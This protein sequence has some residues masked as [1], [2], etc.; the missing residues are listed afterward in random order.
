M[1]Q[2]KLAF[3]NNE[4]KNAVLALLDSGKAAD[5]RGAFAIVMRERGIRYDK[6]SQKETYSVHFRIT[7]PLVTRTIKAR[8]LP[9][10][11]AKCQQ[12]ISAPASEDWHRHEFA[13]RFREG[14]L[15]G[16]TLD[17]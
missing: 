7:E 6:P 16:F 14:Q 4:L 10:P 13:I 1:A 3:G 5:F 8:K 11:K 15:S 12:K 9:K 17:P 2:D